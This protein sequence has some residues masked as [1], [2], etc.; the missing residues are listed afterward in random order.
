MDPYG[1]FERNGHHDIRNLKSLD[2]VSSAI[3]LVKH[4]ATP[5]TLQPQTRMVVSSP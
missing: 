5:N 2:C 1:V 4:Q 3:V